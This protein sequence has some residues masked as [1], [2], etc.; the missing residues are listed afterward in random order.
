MTLFD[1]DRKDML[2]WGI[3]ELEVMVNMWPITLVVGSI[4]MGKSIVLF[5]WTSCTQYR[6][7]H[8]GEALQKQQNR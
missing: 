4:N 7:C 5:V 8:W 3:A 6:K 2:F 1:E